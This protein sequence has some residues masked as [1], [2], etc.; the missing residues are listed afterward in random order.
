M[1]YDGI[2]SFFVVFLRPCCFALQQFPFRKSLRCKKQR[3]ESRR[4]FFGCNRDTFAQNI[5]T[6]HDMYD[7]PDSIH[8]F[9]GT[10]G[11]WVIDDIIVK[12]RCRMQ[13]FHHQCQTLVCDRWY[14]PTTSRIKTTMGRIRLPETDKKWLIILFTTA[15]SERENGA[16][17]R[18]KIVKDLWW[19]HGW[20]QAYS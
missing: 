13:E 10:A 18:S 14:C 12:Q 7:I 8:G 16:D 15:T 2:V 11:V 19:V 17:P 20:N 1:L 4:I 3:A 5:I 9:Q 6:E